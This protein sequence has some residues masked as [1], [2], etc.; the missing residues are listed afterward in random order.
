MINRNEILTCMNSEFCEICKSKCDEVKTYKN[1]KG[2]L[3]EYL[4]VGCLVDDELIDYAINVLPPVTMT[5]NMVQIGE[6]YSHRMDKNGK[7]RPTYST[8]VKTNEGWVYAGHCF[9]GE[10]I[11]RM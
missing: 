11:N 2:D 7:Y 6:P 5:Y 1:W 8:F 10:Y 4:F 9:K 3:S